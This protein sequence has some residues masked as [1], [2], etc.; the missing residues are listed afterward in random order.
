MII[1]ISRKPL[2]GSVC[3]NIEAFSCG[4]VNIKA[5]RLSTQAL[6]FID[7]GRESKGTSLNWSKKKVNGESKKRKEMVY[8]G[9]L[10]RF[11][12]N[13]LLSDETGGFLDQ[14]CES[15]GGGASRFFKVIK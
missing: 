4:G 15:S 1:T 11:P 7:K 14:Q 2:A 5:S 6:S 8:D 12:S 9:S 13:V 3:V 10:G